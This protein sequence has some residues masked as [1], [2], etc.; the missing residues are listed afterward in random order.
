[1]VNLSCRHLDSGA[2]ANDEIKVAIDLCCIDFAFHKDLFMQPVKYR[3]TDLNIEMPSGQTHQIPYAHVLVGHRYVEHFAAFHEDRPIRR[4]VVKSFEWSSYS[5]D[6][7]LGP[8]AF[9]VLAN[10][11]NL[12]LRLSGA[13][14]HL[15]WVIVLTEFEVC[16]VMRFFRPQGTG[17]LDSSSYS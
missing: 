14:R 9:P 1:M 13:W 8:P 11:S 4:V 17:F 2:H 7:L 3:T 10:Y 15:L 12:V 5:S 16:T 6:R